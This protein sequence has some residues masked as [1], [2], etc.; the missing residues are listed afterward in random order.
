MPE[1]PG[2]AGRQPSREPGET[3]WPASN[4]PWPASNPPWVASN[5]PWVVS[6]HTADDPAGDN[7]PVVTENA[8]TSPPAGRGDPRAGRQPW[9]SPGHGTTLTAMVTTVALLVTGGI[10][11][12]QVARIRSG[13]PAMDTSLARR[14]SGPG[15]PARAPGQGRAAARAASSPSTGSSAS[16][17]SPAAHGAVTVAPAVAVQPH[18]RRVVMLLD[19]YFAAINH[20]D[21]PAYSGL[22]IPAIRATMHN[23]GAGYQSTRDSRARLTGLSATGPQG[24]AAMVT[25]VSHQEPA[26][27]PD[28]AMCDRWRITMFLKRDAGGYH[29]RRHQPG[30]PADTVRAC[31]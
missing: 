13:P 20:H 28:H 16:P 22:F 24:L 8:T 12:W 14:D 6:A 15:R 11:A 25:F 26:E 29:I 23:F 21:F 30:F 27:S 5:P 3:P 10:A 18:V 9:L 4:P 7:P 17:G 19:N 2:W 1:D 31:R